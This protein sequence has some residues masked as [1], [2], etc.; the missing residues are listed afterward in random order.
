MPVLLFALIRN[1]LAM[2]QYYHR[3]R[4]EKRKPAPTPPNDWTAGILMPWDRGSVPKEVHHETPQQ[5]LVRRERRPR[6]PAPSRLTS[7]PRPHGRYSNPYDG[8]PEKSRTTSGLV[9]LPMAL[10]GSSFRASSRVG[11]L[12][13]A[14]RS[15]AQRRSSSSVS[16]SPGASTRAA[17]MR[18]PH[19]GSGRPTTATSRTAGCSRTASSISRAETLYPP[20]LR[21]STLLRP[22]IR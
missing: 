20:V 9:T 1:G 17:P 3:A 14:S 13:G 8:K 19:S 16:A 6:L 21:M 18:S 11:N 4:R 15:P 22:R 5:L 12:Y 10:R 2:S 7:D